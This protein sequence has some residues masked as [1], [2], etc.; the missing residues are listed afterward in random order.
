ML[1]TERRRSV[2]PGHE[3]EMHIDLLIASGDRSQ[4]AVLARELDRQFGSYVVCRCTDVENMAASALDAR[5]DV[6]L[7]DNAPRSGRVA[8]LLSQVRLSNPAIRVLLLFHA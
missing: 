1:K 4:C 3:L 5:T 2:D 6:L 7:V 8:A